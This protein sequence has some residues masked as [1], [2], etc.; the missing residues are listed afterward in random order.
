MNQATRA[1]SVAGI[2]FLDDVEQHGEPFF[3]HDVEVGIG[4]ARLFTCNFLG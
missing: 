4:I 3:I 2:I 1:A